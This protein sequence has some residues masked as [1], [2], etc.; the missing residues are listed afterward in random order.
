M[1]EQWEYVLREMCSV[2]GADFDTMDFQ[3][4]RW[5]TEYTW[6]EQQQDDFTKWME[7]YLKKKSIAKHFTN[8]TLMHRPKVIA[9]SFVSNYGWKLKEITNKK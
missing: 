1:E 7:K 5:F 2:V 6:T 9:E 3:K 8:Y 4:D